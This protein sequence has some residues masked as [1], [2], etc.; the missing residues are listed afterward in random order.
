MALEGRL[1]RLERA[2]GSEG[3]EVNGGI[4]IIGE[5]AEVET[6]MAELEVACSE[7]RTALIGQ[8]FGPPEFDPYRAAGFRETRPIELTVGEVRRLAEATRHAARRG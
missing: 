3:E 8:G 7:L 1:R 6:V 5:P 2:L 4:R